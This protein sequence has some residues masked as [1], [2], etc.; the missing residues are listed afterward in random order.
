MKIFILEDEP[1]VREYLL[2]ILPL[3]SL[4]NQ[5]IGLAS[6]LKEA[7][8]LLP[9]LKPD[10][11]LFDVELPDGQSFELLKMKNLPPAHVIFITAHNAFALQAIKFSALDYL[12]KPIDEDELEQALQKAQE[13]LR[14]DALH[15]QLELLE[16]NLQRTRPKRLVLKDAT[17][18]HLVQ[19]QDILR[20]EASG[21]YTH[22][23]LRNGDQLVMTQTLKSYSTML[24]GAGF[25]RVHHSHLVNLDAIQRIDK[26]EG[27]ILCLEDG[28][29]V[30]ISVRRKDS[31]LKALGGR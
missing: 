5:I 20:L 24:E 14:A 22:F 12:L 15:S 16:E 8:T 3:L 19:T 18:I 28:S 30:P 27:L 31:L 10:L 29:E 6:S 2:T 21:S 1:S 26:S 7:Q 9:N 23:F 25:F 11:L 17:Q 13:R 4:E